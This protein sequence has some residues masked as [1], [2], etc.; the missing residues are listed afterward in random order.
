MSVERW[1]CV[2]CGQI[3]YLD[4]NVPLN[5]QIDLEHTFGDEDRTLR[6]WEP[7]EHEEYCQEVDY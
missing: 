6:H 5:Q 3:F 7:G 1:M 4:P 2:D